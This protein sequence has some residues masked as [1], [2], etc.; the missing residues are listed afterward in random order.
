MRMLDRVL[1]REEWPG[2][3][4]KMI[5]GAQRQSTLMAHDTVLSI[6]G[7]T[8]PEGRTN[9]VASPVPNG[10][11]TAR[12]ALAN[13]ASGSPS[14]GAGRGFPPV[15]SLYIHVPFCF[16]K[17]HYCDFYS[18]VDTR[19]RQGAF[20]DRLVRELAALAPLSEGRVGEV[21]GLRTIFVGGGTPSLLRVEL[22]D[23]V[24][25]ALRELFDLSG[26]GRSQEKRAG[27]PLHQSQ[28]AG[29]PLHRVSETTGEFTVECN[30]E[31][32][33][34]ELMGVLAAGGV[35]RVSLGAQSFEARHLKTLE[36]WHDPANV[37]RAI[38]LARAAGIERQ[39]LDLIYA[40]PGQTIEEWGRDLDRAVAMGTTHVSAYN[41]T[42][43]PNTAMTARK[44]R[45]EFSPMEEE[46]EIE[47]FELAATRLQAAGLERYEVSN[48]AV[49]GEEAR[50]NLSYWCQ[51]QWLAAG[52]SASAHVRGMRWKNTPRLD[53]Y[54]SIE[55][56]GYSPIV[57]FEGFDAA[58]ALRERIM[59]G[60]R[61]REGLDATAILQDA[62]TLNAAWPE[63]LQ[64][65]VER[66]AGSGHV[67]V[68]TGDGAGSRWR[69]TDAGML[70]A[71][72]VAGDLMAAC[73]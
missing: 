34:P 20:V 45:G 58:R 32:V 70:L 51:E 2:E 16:H 15:G 40:I 53:D 33:T 59:T 22:W 39:S 23:R 9:G 55:D 29:N 67:V 60:L 19:D 50:H 10:P 37:A 47:M 69:L 63:R 25:L 5:L 38:E 52:P 66:W 13:A 8:E 21:G 41:L 35:N 28:R 65:R 64:R 44:N 11:R 1:A 57:D 54:L 36:R 43:E 26:M 18:L 72:G 4:S 46:L 24:L 17:C 6:L 7:Q 31:T 62:A 71:D 61:L 14:A 12:E 48:Y 27:R 30:P 56:A 49:P 73:R 68:D 3:C 42:Y